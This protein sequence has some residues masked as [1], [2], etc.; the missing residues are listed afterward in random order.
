VENRKKT[1]TVSSDWCRWWSGKNVTTS[2]WSC[3]GTHRKRSVSCARPSIPEWSATTVPATRR[4]FPATRW[5]SSWRP[6]SAAA[7]YIQT[8]PGRLSW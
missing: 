3:W 8:T 2:A 5:L 1:R 4:M 7:S 6:A